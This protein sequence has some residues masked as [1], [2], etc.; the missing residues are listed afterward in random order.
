MSPSRLLEPAS[1]P[2]PV[3][4]PDIAD[5]S[6]LS[7]G[8]RERANL[9]EILATVAREALE[10]D[11][12]DGLLQRVVEFVHERLPVTIVSVILLDPGGTRFEK[13]VWTGSI[14]LEQPGESGEWPVTIGLAGRCARTGEPQLVLDVRSDP[15]YV[16]G[17]TRVAAEYLVPIRHR[18]EIL[19]VLNLESVDPAIFTPESIRAFD[20]I[21]DQV[22]G[23]IRLARLNERLEIANR[24]LQRLTRV[25]PLTGIANRRRFDEALDSEW[26]RAQREGG[27][28]SLL[29]I[30]ADRFK[31]LNDAFGHQFGDACLERLAGLFVG[32]LRRAADLVAR[33]G[34][35]EFGILLPGN[36]RR[37]AAELAERLRARVEGESI[38]HPGT[39]SERVTVS[40]GA[41][42]VEPRQDLRPEDLVAAADEALYR[43]KRAGRN[44]VVVADRV[45][46]ADPREPTEGTK[47]RGRDV[48]APVS[49]D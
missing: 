45:P 38:E 13:E 30:D 44:R 28:L 1:G 6:E 32:E 29:L 36:D 37:E 26:R 47:A 48:L 25:D 35:E 7:E 39:P 16:P 41:A 10:A 42:T 43:A 34:G 3:S 4:D 27:A 49:G 22:A 5:A 12:L 15:D 11:S 40:V 9:L 18:D 33:Y 2:A 17:N 19:G 46:L 31:D 21:A 23:A 14:D 24:E 20:G 8:L